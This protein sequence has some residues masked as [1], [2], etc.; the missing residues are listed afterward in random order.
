[1]S[2]KMLRIGGVVGVVVIGWL[3]MLG[4]PTSAPQAAP[5]A[6]QV[7]P[8]YESWVCLMPLLLFS[9]ILGL[10]A[11]MSFKY[12]NIYM[13]SKADGWQ[14]DAQI[15]KAEAAQAAQRVADFTMIGGRFVPRA[16]VGPDGQ[17]L[18]VSPEI[19]TAAVQGLDPAAAQADE[20]PVRM[21]ALARQAAYYGGY[22]GAGAG[23]GGDAGLTNLAAVLT[24]IQSSSGS[25]RV[26]NAIPASVRVLPA[27]ET[28]ALPNGA[29]E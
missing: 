4:W 27:P 3:V 7:T 24:M 18:L 29:E 19:M 2:G 23:R 8:W 15:R 6:P 20:T 21:L 11:G 26:L 28:E 5:T 22:G 14:A 25:G 9:V 17:T 12:G 1:M 16:L 10:L 13:K